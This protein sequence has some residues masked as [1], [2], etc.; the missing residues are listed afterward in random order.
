VAAYETPIIQNLDYLFY[1]KNKISF[2]KKVVK[3]EEVQPQKFIFVFDNS[4]G[5]L[6]KPPPSSSNYYNE[7]KKYCTSINKLD[8]KKQHSFTYADILK[9]RL[10]FDL[11]KVLKQ[12]NNTSEFTILKIGCP[13]IINKLN[14]TDGWFTLNKDIVDHIIEE[15]FDF[16]AES[17]IS[18]FSYLYK[19]IQK[20][21]DNNNYTVFIYSDFIHDL[22]KNKTEP[23]E[24]E[25]KNL[26]DHLSNIRDIQ[27]ELSRRKITQN[28]FFVPIN[29]IEKDERKVLPEKDTDFI[30]RFD[31]GIINSQALVPHKVEETNKLL[32]PYF[33]NIRNL[34]RNVKSSLRLEFS[35]AVEHV[36]DTYNQF[37]IYKNAKKIEGNEYRHQERNLLNSKKILITYHQDSPS[38]LPVPKLQIFRKGKLYLSTCHFRERAPKWEYIGWIL[39]SIAAGCLLGFIVNIRKK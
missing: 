22:T 7:Y 36:I 26:N 39:G 3:N 24:N 10:A 12:N 9:A 27:E 13:S 25:E 17:E 37:V 15:L 29:Q 32:F 35:D 31:I 5:Y 6:E 8:Y 1:R 16:T 38:L 28:L 20:L 21:C 23:N 34:N 18:N 14:P 4:G 11:V 30:R 33:T 19:S 2:D